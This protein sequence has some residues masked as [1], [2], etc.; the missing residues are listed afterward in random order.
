MPLPPDTVLKHYTVTAPIQGGGFGVTYKAI[1]NRTQEQVAIKE[2]YPSYLVSRNEDGSIRLTGSKDE[3]DNASRHFRREAEILCDLH[4]PG[5]VCV[6]DYFSAL[7]TDYYVMEYVDGCSLG[8]LSP[9]C[10]ATDESLAHLLLSLADALSYIHRLKVYHRDIKPS[11]IMLRREN[12]EPL[13]IDFGAARCRAGLLNHSVSSGVYSEGYSS[14]E[15]MANDGNE[16]PWMDIYS[17]GATF[18]RLL[19]GMTPPNASARLIRDNAVL[20]AQDRRL[21]R[22]YSSALLAC[23]DKAFAVRRELRYRTA[24]EL[25]AD[26]EAA[27]SADEEPE[28]VAPP[29]LS[30]EPPAPV[31]P[32]PSS[33]K[34]KRPTLEPKPVAEDDIV[35]VPLILHW[36]AVLSF[37]IGT[38]LT[39][40]FLFSLFGS[41]T[42]EHI[43]DWLV[44]LGFPLLILSMV[45]R[46][47]RRFS[48]DDA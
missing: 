1:D 4:H 6:T 14:P 24:A 27:L 19:T 9:A 46:I 40:P 30:E 31:T 8:D 3:F 45:F 2:N 48:A 21:T 39:V 26:V 10:Y 41:V 25:A 34:L 7:G 17:L 22:R 36:G 20:L 29:V 18:Y 44:L 15:Q 37:L 33:E 16:G 28:E 47:M 38:A 43:A 35:P 12:G 42:Q 11:N 23:I 5:V 13:L 32:G